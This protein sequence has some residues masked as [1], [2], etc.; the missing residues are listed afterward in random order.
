MSTHKLHNET[1]AVQQLLQYLAGQMDEA[2]ADLVAGMI[3]GET[4]YFEAID[5]V[6]DLRAE[7]QMLIE[8]IGERIAVLT[9]RKQAFERRDESIR[10]ALLHSMEATGLQ[11]VQRPLATLS[12][13]S[14]PVTAIVTDEAAIPKDY[15]T[16]QPDKLDKRA[17]LAALKDGVEIPGAALS[18]GG[19]TLSIRSK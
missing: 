18:N 4:R 10:A 15:K 14:K 19:T 12:L 13:A 1:V 6:L 5:K 9:A 17:L 7:T 8:G 16:P 3:E 2:D 11:K